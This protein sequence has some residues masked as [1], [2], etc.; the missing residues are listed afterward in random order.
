MG[1]AGDSRLARIETPHREIAKNALGDLGVNEVAAPKRRRL[2]ADRCMKFAR[3]RK[4][5]EGGGSLWTGRRSRARFTLLGVSMRPAR[6]PLHHCTVIRSP[7]GVEN[8]L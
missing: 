4:R 2:Y 7:T 8:P 6:R 1:Q 5:A 3:R